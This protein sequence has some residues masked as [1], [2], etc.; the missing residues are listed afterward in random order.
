MPSSVKMA[1]SP[2]P[3]YYSSQSWLQSRREDCKG[4]GPI[5]LAAQRSA[6]DLTGAFRDE[7]AGPSYLEQM[8]GQWS[9]LQACRVAP[10]VKPQ[11]SIGGL[12]H[13]RVALDLTEFNVHV[14]R[15]RTAKAFGPHELCAETLKIYNP[16]LYPVPPCCSSRRGY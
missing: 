15:A 13:L 14:G 3:M 11:T 10:L 16:W 12:S 4:A 1:T 2:A 9:A 5:S 6:V 8:Q 7:A